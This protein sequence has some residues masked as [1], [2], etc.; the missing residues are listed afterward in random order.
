MEGSLGLTAAGR[1]RRFDIAPQGRR[2]WRDLRRGIPAT[3]ARGP[4]M[5][6]GARRRAD[7]E[8]AVSPRFSSHDRSA[9]IRTSLVRIGPAHRA[10]QCQMRRSRE[11]G[12]VQ[13]SFRGRGAFADVWGAAVGRP[14]R[15]G[16]TVARIWEWRVVS[17]AA[18]SVGSA[19]AAP[20]EWVGARAPVGERARSE[21]PLARLTGRVTGRGTG[22]TLRRLRGRHARELA[23]DHGPR[24]RVEHRRSGPG[25]VNR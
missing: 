13:R 14:G 5:A 22:A 6:P 18:G 7:L 19:G 10:R 15:A 17:G 20:G 9:E 23:R 24:S 3:W 11:F 21:L 25:E 2:S 16:A 4:A 8:R 12:A 1:P